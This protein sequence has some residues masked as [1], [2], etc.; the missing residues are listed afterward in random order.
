MKLSD[1][2]KKAISKTIGIP[3]DEL[4]KMDD[5]EVIAHIE[6]K[7]GKKVVFSKNPPPVSMM[8]SGDDSVLID[9]GKIRT[10]D[11]VD[12]QIEKILKGKTKMDK[13]EKRVAKLEKS[14]KKF[15]EKLRRERE[16]RIAKFMKFA[17]VPAGATQ[18]QIDAC[19]LWA[20]QQMN[21]NQ[22]HK[23][24]LTDEQ[25][26]NPEFLLSMYA[27]NPLTA[28]FY[29]PSSDNKDLQNNVNFMFE[30]VKR[31]MDV[32][33]Q[34]HSDD[35]VFWQKSE[36]VSA[37]SPYETAIQHSQLFDLLIKQYPEVNMI[38]VIDDCFSRKRIWGKWTRDALNETER[39]FES[40]LKGLSKESLISHTQ[41]FGKKVL[42]K[43]PTEIDFWPELAAVGVKKDGFDSLGYLPIKY[44]LDN[45]NLILQAY[46]KDGAKELASYLTRTLSPHRTHYYMCHG[47]PHDYSTYEEEYAVVQ[48][49]LMSDPEFIAI[50]EKEEAKKKAS[51]GLSKTVEPE[52][53]VE[54]Q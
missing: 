37:L 18:E 8:G 39:E 14:N 6:K 36:L 27:S 31:V 10:M 43:L 41:R 33:M 35:L 15:N 12:K 54:K 25:R 50:L 45:K 23:I 47:E 32:E 16:K 40:V 7:T 20:I 46:E 28:R 44:V 9:Q 51:S 21:Q 52:N 3:F 30:F 26:K 49:A 13:Y 29:K 1:E 24:A 4:I 53:A 2:T 48:A 19:Y 42:S 38:E 11:D 22:F 17:K 34:H 5:E